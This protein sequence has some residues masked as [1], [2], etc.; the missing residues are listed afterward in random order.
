MDKEELYLY[1]ILESIKIIEKHMSKVSFS[2]FMDS[3]IIQDAVSK[4][5]E[6]IGENARKISEKVRK[7]HKEVEW[8]EY[9]ST[10]NFLTHVYQMLNVTRLWKII[11][12][13]LPKLKKQIN[14][15]IKEIK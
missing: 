7:K 3:T 2:K 9:I 14:K 15:I 13:D 11:K 6:E 10:R 4:R 1:N 12:K 8:E 5:L